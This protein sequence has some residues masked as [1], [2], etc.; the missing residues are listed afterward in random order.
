ME[1]WAGIW[2]PPH[3]ALKVKGSLCIL[4]PCAPVTV[5]AC[6]PTPTCRA[7]QAIQEEALGFPRWRGDTSRHILELVTEG[8]LGR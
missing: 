5:S 7:T 4:F 2:E 6:S 8:A 3:L 1:L